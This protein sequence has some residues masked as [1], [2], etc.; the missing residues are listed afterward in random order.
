MPTLN[1]NDAFERIDVVKERKIPML[2]GVKPSLSI[3]NAAIMFQESCSFFPLLGFVD[4]GLDFRYFGIRQ[5]RI[6]CLQQGGD[7][8]INRSA[9]KS[10]QYSFE[11]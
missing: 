4:D 3:P 9:K 7:R 10:V 5:L 6:R 2:P 11:C 1:T 8:G